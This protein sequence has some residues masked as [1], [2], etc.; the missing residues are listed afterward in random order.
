MEAR[1][2]LIHE[3]PDNLDS[4]WK[5][6]WYFNFIDRENNAWGINHVSLMR[7]KKKGRFAAFHVVDGQILMY[8]NMIDIDEN[9]KEVTDGRLK[10][11]FVKPFKKFRLTLDGPQHKVDLN[12][13]ARFDVFDY[14]MGKPV[15]P[16]S[17]KALNIN[18][19]E[20][21]LTVKGTIEKDGSTRKINCLG[22]RDHSWGYRNESKV[23]GWNWAAVQMKDKTIN[24]SRVVIGEAY[25][26][27]GFI[28]NKKGNTRV[29]SVNLENTDFED[30]LP[31]RS[32]FVAQ[33]ESGKTWKLKSE[34]FSGLYL[35]MK[36]KGAGVVVH[37]N[38]ADYV[39][40]DTGEKGVGIDE[41]LIN[42]DLH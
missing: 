9:L 13:K 37:E 22:H 41:Y 10:F 19:Y 29:V 12:Y 30:N 16:G 18:H 5:E 6:N 23:T 34:K 1:D 2:E 26:G 7:D 24:L 31:V 27:S 17:N 25:I 3:Y 36:E 8:A 28:S 38:F 20:Q 14:A 32:T 35:P 42:P 11:D 15:K 4:P 21:A 40:V 33:D 39:D